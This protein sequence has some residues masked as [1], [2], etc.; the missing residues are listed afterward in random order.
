M[1]VALNNAHGEQ[2]VLSKSIFKPSC[3]CLRLFRLGNQVP[4]RQVVDN[5]LHLLDV[6]LDAVDLPAYDVVL[7][8]QQLEPGEQ[9]LDELADANRKFDISQGDRVHGQAAELLGEVGHG[10][11][12][13]LNGNVKGVSVFEV[14]GDL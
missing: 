6:I 7:Q 14:D 9:V 11:N 3:L 12:V 13:F 10:E 5:I 1:C 4:K 2:V 8:V